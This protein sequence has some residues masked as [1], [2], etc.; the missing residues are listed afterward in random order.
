MRAIVPL[1]HKQRVARSDERDHGA[2]LHQR[3]PNTY[4]GQ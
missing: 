1:D 3:A 2:T 4:Y